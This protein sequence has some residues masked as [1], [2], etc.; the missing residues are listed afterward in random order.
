MELLEARKLVK[1]EIQLAKSRT[2]NVLTSDA[3]EI[4]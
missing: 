2:A 1:L 3:K 4:K